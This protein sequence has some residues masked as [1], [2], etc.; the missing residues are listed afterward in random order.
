M[1]TASEQFHFYGPPEL[2]E[3]LQSVCANTH[4]SAS[5]IF[6]RGLENTLAEIEKT[7]RLP[8]CTDKQ[9]KQNGNS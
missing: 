4:L 7:G 8:F 6:R 3:R 9:G 2:K 5:A 1:L